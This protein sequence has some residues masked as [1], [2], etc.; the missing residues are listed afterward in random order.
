[1]T[2][3]PIPV[4]VCEPGGDVLWYNRLAQQIVLMGE[5]GHAERIQNIIGETDISAPSPQCGYEVSYKGRYYNVYISPVAD[6]QNEQ[7]TLY[8]TYFFDITQLKLINLEYFESRPVIMLIVVDNYDELQQNLKDSER[9]RV[10]AQ[11]EYEVGQY[12]SRYGGL[13]LKAERDRFTAVMEERG[14]SAI[15]SSRF[16]ILEKIRGLE[17]ADKQTATLSIGVGHDATKYEESE[18]FARQALD[19]ALGRGGDQAAVRGAGGYEFFGGVTNGVEKR[20]KVKTRIVASAL[21]ELIKGSDNVFVM[22]H[23]NADLDS[24][25]SSFGMMRAARMLGKEAYVVINREQNLVNDLITRLDNAGFAG[26]ILNP[27]AAMMLVLKKSLLIICDTHIQAILD[28]KEI[29]EA[30][31]S[32]VVIDHHRKMVGHIEN[33][34]IFYHEPY[35]SSAAEMVTELLPYFGDKVNIGRAEAEALLS[36]IML[37]TKN[38]VLKTGVRTFEAAAYLRKAGADTVEVRRLFASSMDSYQRKTRLVAN[39]KIYKSCAIAVSR[40][41]DV[42]D[43]QVT[44]AQAADELLNIR[45]VQASFLIFPQ[46]GGMSYSA[47]SMGQL[48][49]QLIME[50]LGGGGHHTMA[51]AQEAGITAE[52]A[53]E[54]LIKA[55]DQFFEENTRK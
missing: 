28:S 18:Q 23:R 33:A 26:E 8:V 50:K 15:M 55:I 10:M 35:A 4:F 54:K 39:A 45:G 24:F 13:L 49:V 6:E 41:R 53:L 48:N 20:T 27:D 2:H 52:Q 14:L 51:G 43:I 21:L 46:G 42:P 11:I 19:M 1:M 29:Y 40:D 34:V 12:I 3:F 16:S 17:N 7:D 32:V 25:G 5:N 31:R 9:T 36:G 30:C 47:R 44:A 38:F 37:D 22:G